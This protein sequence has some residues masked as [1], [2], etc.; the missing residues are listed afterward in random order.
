MI[1][2]HADTSAINNSMAAQRPALLVPGDC[3]A[4]V[5]PASAIDPNL[6]AGAVETLRALGY[7]PRVSPHALDRHGSYSGSADERL[8]DMTAALSD[9]DVKAILCSRGGYG[10]VQLLER[11]RPVL[12]K[13]TPKW[14]IGFSDISVLHALWCRRGIAGIHGSMAKQLAAGVDTEATRRLMHILT[15]GHNELSWHT[16]STVANRSGHATAPL[17]GGNLAVL[18]ALIGTD[19]SAIAPGDI[20]F[21][22]DVAE[23][24]YKIERML[25]HMKLSG[26]L[27]QLS[28]LIVGRF[29]DYRPDANHDSME[30]M[31]AG[32]VAEYDFPVAY[33]APIGHTG[34]SNMPVIHGVVTDLT[35]EAVSCCVRQ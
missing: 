34:G 32:M 20:L 12:T 18:D 27:S 2:G 10:A 4:I 16:A 29:T 11:L 6:V 23:P 24:I 8:A 28:G 35:V 25:Y 5:S 33:D 21:I 22:E 13:Y 19:F 9:P 7:T 14:L 30:S 31:V 17:K 3:I 26:L 1:N 15:T